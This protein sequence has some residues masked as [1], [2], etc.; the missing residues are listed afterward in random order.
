MQGDDQYRQLVSLMES[1]QSEKCDK[2]FF[3]IH[4]AAL[5]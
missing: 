4:A 1:K 3:F 5:K 2:T